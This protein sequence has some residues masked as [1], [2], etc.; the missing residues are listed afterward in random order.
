MV[1]LWPPA[2]PEVLVRQAEA[3]LEAQQLDRAEAA[4][5]QLGRLRPA[6]AEDWKL[7]ARVATARGRIEE[8]VAAWTQIP[9][10]HPEAAEA[11][12]RTGQLEL[13]RH[14]V[15]QAEAAFLRALEL[16]PEVV[17]AHR[18]LIYI[19]GML[20]RWPALRAQFEALGR[21]TDL[22]F[23]NVFLWCQTRLTTWEPEEQKRVLDQFLEADP[24]DRQTRLALATTLVQLGRHGDAEA[25]LGA[26]PGSDP[27]ARAIRTRSALDRGDVPAAVALLAEGPADHPDLARL[28]G[29]L[30]LARR[31]GA[32]AVRHFR[33]ALAAEPDDR[34]ALSGLGAALRMVGDDA[35]AE[36]VLKAA[37]DLDLLSSL[38]HRAAS[39]AHRNDPR[40]LHDLG[41]ACA[42]VGRRP[43]AR[44]W[45]RLAI[46]RD[47]LD[48][49][50]Q[51]ALFRLKEG[52]RSHPGTLKNK[53]FERSLSVP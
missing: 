33:V 43:E 19:Y 20:L 45:F 18:E 22:T 32:E 11:R 7:R 13:R 27:D 39:S 48:R 30:A 52:T 34:D 17:Q 40:L 16:N 36:P 49:A 29:R 50:S 51:R 41:A 53:G 15:R 42:A 2:D 10:G 47:P 38:V 24:D 14:R 3:D 1:I 44:A 9:D 26:L 28:R 21:K 25:V 12:L 8:A 6:T 46:L 35:A 5:R 31:Q 4:V 23:D 37:R